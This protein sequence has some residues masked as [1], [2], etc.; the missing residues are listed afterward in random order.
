MLRESTAKFKDCKRIGKNRFLTPR[1][2]PPTFYLTQSGGIGGYPTPLY[3]KSATVIP[4]KILPT[5]AKNDVFVSC[6]IAM[7]YGAD[8][9]YK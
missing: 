9:S 3:G 2:Y 7:C 5:R 8:T 1:G 4:A 6:S